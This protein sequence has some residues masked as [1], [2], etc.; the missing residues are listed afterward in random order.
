MENIL[1]VI[2]SAILVPI[3]GLF[4][5]WIKQHYETKKQRI[6]DSKKLEIIIDCLNVLVEHTDIK[7]EV[8]DKIASNIKNLGK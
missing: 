5:L 6:K 1:I 7:Q 2:S 8:K 3:I 4:S